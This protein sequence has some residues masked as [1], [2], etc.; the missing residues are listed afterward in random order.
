M[1][2]IDRLVIAR[3]ILGFEVMFSPELVDKRLVF[4]VFIEI[5]SFDKAAGALWMVGC[6][7]GWIRCR[8]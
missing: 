4:A 2:S 7:P 5:S 3:L 8:V 6:L 1:S